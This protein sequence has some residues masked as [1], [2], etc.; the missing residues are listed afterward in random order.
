MNLELLNKEA[1]AYG[2]KIAGDVKS[3]VLQM[4]AEKG[5]LIT[6]MIPPQ[7]RD[8]LLE[9]LHEMVKTHMALA[10]MAGAAWLDPRTPSRFTESVPASGVPVVLEPE[11]ANPEPDE[12]KQP[13][14]VEPDVRL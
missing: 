2:D 9:K 7:A 13:G 6:A 8:Q 10:F 1:N 4:L 12:L 5:P 3:Q 11:P 14:P